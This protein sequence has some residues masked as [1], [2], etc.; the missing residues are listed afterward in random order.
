MA[1]GA[2]IV[3]ASSGIGRALAIEYANAG[4][5]VGVTARRGEL[6]QQL[7][8]A[9]PAGA[10]FRAF[11]IAEPDRAI[12]QLRDLVAEMGDVEVFVISAAIGNNNPSLEWAKE[13]DTLSINVLGAAAMINVAVE[14]LQV[15][16]GGHL[17]GLSSI[18]GIRG[19]GRAPA[20]AASK[21]FLSNYLHGLR[22][23]FMR[24]GVP[25]V[26]TDVQPGFVDT[27]LAGARFWMASPEQA[28]R[29]IIAAVRRG[30]THVYVTKR[31]RLIAWLI[32]VVP[33]AVW[34][35]V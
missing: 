7:C 32:R 29:Q 35:R 33:D 5:R 26:V 15:R 2:I 21:A 34:G 19:I 1:L 20:Y 22:Y 23:R 13:H 16:G 8:E 14:H 12:P 3:G 11:D 24:L 31:W 30:R 10:V 4:Y 28:A 27:R 9:L 17:V 18:A 6:L 25:I